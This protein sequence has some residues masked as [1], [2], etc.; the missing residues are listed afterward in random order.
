MA[1]IVE[2]EN[3]F[4]EKLGLAEGQTL[5]HKLGLAEGQALVDKLGELLNNKLGLAENQTLDDKLGLGH[6]GTNNLPKME[7]APVGESRV[8]VTYRSIART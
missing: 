3:L 4:N 2:I 8:G 1:S 5:D 6:N 7:R